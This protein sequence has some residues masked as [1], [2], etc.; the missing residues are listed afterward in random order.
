MPIAQ[1]HVRLPQRAWSVG[2]GVRTD[3]GA[4]C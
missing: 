1:E 3:L 4:P 2:L